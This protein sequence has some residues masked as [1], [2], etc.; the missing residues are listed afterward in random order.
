MK[1]TL[2]LDDFEERIEMWHEDSLTEKSLH[3]YL[4]ISFERYVQLV[5]AKKAELNTLDG[6]TDE[7]LQLTEDVPI[8]SQENYISAG[9]LDLSGR[10]KDTYFFSTPTYAGHYQITPGFQINLEERP[11]QKFIDN[12]L[13]MLGWQ[14]VDA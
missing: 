11:E 1:K 8:E 13:D 3:E 10:V 14:W 12:H 5:G 7:N 9:T 4:G 2:T 6:A